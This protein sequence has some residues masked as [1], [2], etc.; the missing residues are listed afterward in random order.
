[1]PTK[2]SGKLYGVFATK[3]PILLNTSETK[4]VSYSA[5][6]GHPWQMRRVSQRSF[7]SIL[8]C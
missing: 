1:M 8:K 7:E 2:Y 3:D 6:M 5:M 4:M